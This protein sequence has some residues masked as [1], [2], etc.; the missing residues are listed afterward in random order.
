MLAKPYN[1]TFLLR[2][3]K[4][5]FSEASAIPT[6][7]GMETTSYPKL[8]HLS[9]IVCP[10]LSPPTHLMQRVTCLGGH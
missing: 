9:Q 5:T 8:S 6:M 10:L 4:K 1:C 3:Y 2:G 7:A